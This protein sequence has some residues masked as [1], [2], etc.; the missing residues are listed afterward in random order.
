MTEPKPARKMSE[1]M[2]DTLEQ[3]MAFARGEVRDI[4]ELLAHCESMEEEADM[5][6]HLSDCARTIARI[7]RRLA[8]AGAQ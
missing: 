1:K 8:K 4:V 6:D 3:K 7:A 5:A 2:R